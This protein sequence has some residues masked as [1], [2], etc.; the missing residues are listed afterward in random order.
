MKGFRLNNRTAESIC[1]AT[2]MSVEDIASADVSLVDDAIQKKIDRVLTPSVDLGGI[3]PRG[4]VYLMFDRFLTNK[5]INKG[6]S[7]IRP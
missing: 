1:R 6:I 3:L 2:G 4:S 5:D 7:A